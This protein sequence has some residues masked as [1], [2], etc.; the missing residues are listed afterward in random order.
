MLKRKEHDQFEVKRQF[1]LDVSKFI[2]K[3]IIII[4][5]LNIT[6]RQPEVQYSKQLHFIYQNEIR[7]FAE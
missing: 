2:I 3:F 1:S 7:K 5:K 4:S 6:N